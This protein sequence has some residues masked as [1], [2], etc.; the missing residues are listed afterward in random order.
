[1]IPFILSVEN[2]QINRN[3]TIEVDDNGDLGLRRQL[4]SYQLK[5]EWLLMRMESLGNDENVLN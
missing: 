4:E 1:M 2:S 3:M 5:I